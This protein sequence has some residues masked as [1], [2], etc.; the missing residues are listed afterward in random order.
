M[1]RPKET[2]PA[3]ARGGQCCLKALLLSQDKKKKKLA[4]VLFFFF[5]LM[6]EMENN[7]R[8]CVRFWLLS[9][10]GSIPV[11][12]DICGRVSR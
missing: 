8:Q 11:F 5:F 6:H 7:F 1:V 4:K 2:I 9:S 10:S 12:G 3:A